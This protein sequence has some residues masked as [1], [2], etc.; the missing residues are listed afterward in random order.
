MDLTFEDDFPIPTY[1]QWRKVTETSLKGKAFETL[2]TKLLDQIVL[3]PMYQ[4]K[5]IEEKEMLGYEAGVFPFVRST[6]VNPVPFLISQEIGAATPKLLHGKLKH[7]LGRGQNVIHILLENEMK[8]GNKPIRQ[9]SRS[10]VPLFNLHDVKEMVGDIDV[11]SIP[12]HIDAG[13]VSLPLL[14]AMS[15][16]TKRLSGTI[17]SDPL[18]Q[19]VKEGMLLY[20]LNMSYD[21]MAMAVKW[22]SNNHTSLRTVL[23]QSYAYHNGGASPAMEVAIALSTGVEYVEALIKRGV[24]ATDAGKSITFS[25]SI[26]SSFFTEVS[27][28]RAARSLWAVIMAEFGAEEIGQKMNVHARTSSFTKSK[29]DT[30]VNLLRGT[31]EAFAAAVAGVNSLHVSAFDEP[32]QESTD[33]SRRIARN[34]S[35]ILQEE[36]YLRATVDPAGGS[37][38]VESLTQQLAKKVWEQFQ[39]IER[40]G[41]MSQSLQLGYI[42]KKIN[43]YWEVQVKDVKYRRTTMVGVNRYVN[44]N[45][46]QP[47]KPPRV[48]KEKD[49]YFNEVEKIREVEHMK[50]PTTMEDVITMISQNMPFHQIHDQWKAQCEAIKIDCVPQRRLG[51]PFEELR[52]RSSHLEKVNKIVPTIQLI[53]LGS[54]ASHKNRVDFIQE[55][56]QC[57]GFQVEVSDIVETVEEARTQGFQQQIVVICGND[58]SYAQLVEPLMKQKK[59]E[60]IFLAGLPKNQDELQQMGIDGFLHANMNVYQF[61]YDVQE[62]LGGSSH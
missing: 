59:A 12:V 9:K 61:L 16:T 48:E 32:L 51:E 49:A 60:T 4:A 40:E 29:E 23:V 53:R 55:W 30:Y 3:Q 34:T 56:F 38:Y 27:K 35:L 46:K 36:A 62:Q 21:L 50:R 45:E 10:N 24:S 11:S 22:A 1:E 18:H 2:Q 42:Q 47:P 6:N 39:E 44:V 13:V 57:G 25:F 19:L 58:E 15:Q 41:G 33:F 54:L 20:S 26:G 5:D 31:S 14:A 52:D 8:N 7:D 37:W 17:G 43:R 28:I